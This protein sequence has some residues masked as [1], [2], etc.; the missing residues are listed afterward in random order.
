MA[1]GS[2]L[3]D[4]QLILAGAMAELQLKSLTEHW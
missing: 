2:D 4:I 3:W 1:L